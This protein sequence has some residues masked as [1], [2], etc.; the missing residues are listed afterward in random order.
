MQL[1]DDI[2]S[3]A[4][5]PFLLHEDMDALTTAFPH[6]CPILYPYLSDMTIY[7]SQCLGVALQKGFN[8]AKLDS[9]TL[10]T[11]GRSCLYYT[12]RL[13][14]RTTLS[15]IRIINTIMTR[16][17]CSL[18]RRLV[19]I[20]P[21]LETLVIDP[22][23]TDHNTNDDMA[24]MR[25]LL[26]TLKRAQSMR[27]LTLTGMRSELLLNWRNSPATIV[28][29]AISLPNLRELALVKIL[30][31]GM[32]LSDL[33]KALNRAT[34]LKKLTISHCRIKR[35]SRPPHDLSPDMIRLDIPNLRD[36][37][38]EYLHTSSDITERLIPSSLSVLRLKFPCKASEAQILL[39]NVFSRLHANEM[40]VI[41]I[42]IYEI[43]LTPLT[44]ILN[45]LAM[46][47]HVHTLT[48]SG[49]CT[50]LTTSL[51]CNRFMNH[52][53]LPD[54]EHLTL[55]GILPDS[56]VLQIAHLLQQRHVHFKWDV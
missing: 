45:V 54:L 35:L 38:L 31:C 14:Q 13:V 3:G 44:A 11:C 30:P 47:K 27:T 32:V 8:L 24:E 46:A 50:S 33:I 16:K 43:R 48:M 23:I 25:R 1:A 4:V 49:L 52:A 34:Q 19:D 56:F 51:L 37:G 55:L 53:F 42:R 12:L 28:L 5:L 10:R 26:R 36:V 20:N 39:T 21:Q 15:H 17:E 40:T 29:N 6:L 18:I 41:D 2:W 7:S 22:L 9:I